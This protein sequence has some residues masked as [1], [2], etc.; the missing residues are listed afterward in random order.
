M[1][2]KAIETR[3]AG[4]RF[5]SRLEARWAVF[6]DT[7]GIKWEYEPEGYE[8]PGGLYLPDFRIS[9]NKRRAFFEVKP[10]LDKRSI[11]PRW[12]HVASTGTDLYVTFGLPYMTSKSFGMDGFPESDILGG[13]ICFW[14]TGAYSALQFFCVCPH[15]E[16]VDIRWAG[17]ILLDTLAPESN[18]FDFAVD[19]VYETICCGRRIRSP[20]YFGD[21]PNILA[22]YTA[23]R[24]A[25]F[26]HGERG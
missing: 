21:N 23:A 9:L 14:P 12:K 1:T 22:A 25:R 19:R 24:S 11:D 3:Y 18:S 16:A 2:I 8:T 10:E 7:L 26:E 4:C 15:C 20:R 6:F 13:F 17:D 5:R